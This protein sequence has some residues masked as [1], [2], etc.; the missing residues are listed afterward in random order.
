MNAIPPVIVILYVIT[1]MSMLLNVRLGELPLKRRIAAIFIAVIGIAATPVL[2]LSLGAEVYGKYYLLFVQ[3]P[4]YLGFYIVS[5]YKGIKLL[6]VLLSIVVL[7]AP[8]IMC[9]STLRTFFAIPLAAVLPAFLICYVL[10]ALFVYKVLK[11]DFNYM[12]EHCESNRFWLFCLIP[13]LHYIYAYATTHYNFVQP[14]EQ[15]GYFI[16]Q[17]P[18]IIV[19]SSYFLLVRVFRVTREKQILEDEQSMMRLRMEAA[20]HYLNELKST[21]QQTAIYRH[22]MR[23]HLSLLS[24]YAAD[25]DLQKIQKYL[26]GVENDINAVLPMRYCENETVNL[27]LSAFMAKA[28][29]DGVILCA[30][31]H[32]PKVLAIN[33]NELCALFSNALENAVMAAAQLQ[34]EKLR[35]VHIRSVVNG[36][37]LLI[38]T[39]NAYSGKIIM[40]G[41]LPKPDNTEAGHGFGVKSMVSIVKRHGGLYSIET[42]GGVFVLQMMLRLESAN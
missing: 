5:R 25:G 9:V 13:V 36:G 19:F 40:D 17:I 26:S 27:I 39:E 42:A 31:V 2:V 41:E 29:R 24:S 35:R 3:L 6:F 38:A 37:K 22:D 15:Q 32:L 28:K 23:H 14:F 4:V 21:Q 16:Q 10:M 18:A 34:D 7:S 8:P 12:L 11:S 1:V 20:R 33:G 30:E